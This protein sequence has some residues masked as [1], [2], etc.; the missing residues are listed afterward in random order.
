LIPMDPTK[1]TLVIFYFVGGIAVIIKYVL[2]IK[3][4]L[5]N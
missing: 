3:R 4:K 2:D 1:W 5:I